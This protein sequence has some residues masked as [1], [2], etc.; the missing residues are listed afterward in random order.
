MVIREIELSNWKKFKSLKLEFTE[1]INLIYGKNEIGKSTIIEAINY[2]FTK[3]VS[4]SGEDINRL[5]PWGSSLKPKVRVKFTNAEKNLYVFEKKFP[6]G[7]GKIS[8][9]S[10]ENKEIDIIEDKK[11]QSKLLEI[12]GINENIVNLFNLLWINQGETISIF[13]KKDKTLNQELKNHIKDVIRENIVSK[14]TEDFY[15][16]I[17][18]SHTDIFKLNGSLKE[19]TLF[20]TLRN[21]KEALVKEIESLERKIEELNKNFV[22]ISEESEKINK[23]NEKIALKRE[24][25]KKL[26]EK[27]KLSDFAQRKNLEFKMLKDNYLE[28]LKINDEIKN[29]ETNI[30]KFDFFKKRALEKRKLVIEENILNYNNIDAEFRKNEDI[31]KNSKINSALIGEIEK[32]LLEIEKINIRLESQNMKVAII[33]RKKISLSVKIDENDKQ[34]YETD[35]KIEFKANKSFF[36]DY[37]DN[38]TLE[39]DK[40]MSKEEYL[41][42]IKDL[43]SKTSRLREIYDFLGKDD[44]KSIREDFSKWQKAFDDKKIISV[45]LKNFDID[46]LNIEKNDLISRIEDLKDK[47]VDLSSVNE[48]DKISEYDIERLNNEILTLKNKLEYVVDRKKKILNEKKF[49]VL[50]E[51][52]LA[53]KSEI[54]SIEDKLKN[55][56]PKDIQFISDETLRKNN[57][58]LENIISEKNNAEK[59]KISLET[60]ASGVGDFIKIKNQADYKLTEI[61]KEMKNEEVRIRAI[62]LLKRLLEDEKKNLEESILSPLQNR[63]SEAFSRITEKRYENIVL[64]NDFA[65]SGI[66]NSIFDGSKNSLS[67]DAVSYGTK[68]QLSFL[69]RFAI[70]GYLSSKERQV[71]I[72]D[73]SFVNTDKIRL[74]F[75]MELLKSNSDKI[76]FLIFTC[77]DDFQ[78]YGDFINT[79]DLEKIIL[80]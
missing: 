57:F 28:I 68:E 74:K 4:S 29:V 21:E 55:I 40:N 34:N 24:Y 54:E 9:I 72:L 19:K 3:D 52:Y 51:E 63:I 11:I 58:E 14:K 33:P 75:L 30:P 32:I 6:K 65:L 18:E 44:V 45:K 62:D 56:E 12:L 39:V 73:D 50:E 71:M 41:K 60:S 70:A 42:T 49:E 25:I 2:A 78:E 76:Q 79:I 36:M 80:D 35:N 38:F 7:E 17:L 5:V 66:E 67:F 8:F 43:E 77:K 27:K 47:N 26:E 69:F 48:I 23:L 46:R 16:K 61:I 15:K 1:G 37:E 13:D 31:L 53:L 64:S 59:R 10:K 20:F 22:L